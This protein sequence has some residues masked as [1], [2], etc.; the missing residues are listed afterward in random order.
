M[1]VGVGTGL[2]GA[3]RYSVSS[4]VF[5]RPLISSLEGGA[6]G[7]AAG[8]F[9]RATTAYYQSD[10]AGALV[11]ASSGA[12]RFGYLASLNKQALMIEPAASNLCVRSQE[13]DNAA[14]AKTGT[15]P[16]VVANAVNG[17]DGTLTA[18]SFTG[19]AATDYLSL[20]NAVV[21]VASNYVFS[22][23]LRANTGTPAFKV[24]CFDNADSTPSI[25]EIKTLSTSWARYPLTAS[26]LADGVGASP[27]LGGFAGGYTAGALCYLWGAQLELGTG[28]RSTSYIP[29]AAAVATRD[30]DY[31]SYAMPAGINASAGTCSCWVQLPWVTDSPPRTAVSLSESVSGGTRWLGL[32]ANNGAFPSVFYGNGSVNNTVVS[33]I[34]LTG[35]GTFD[36]LTVIWSSVSGVNL[37]V[38]GTLAGTNATPSSI[39]FTGQSILVGSRG[40]ITGQHLGGLIR[41][42]KIWNRVISSAE[43]ATDFA[44]GA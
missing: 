6:V 22:A 20:V 27:N 9:T 37:Y 25:Q 40:V 5:A 1:P 24:G 28:G 33:S 15:P 14:W 21:S 31:L 7:G 35:P 39:D 19:A 2:W 41:N 44:A 43:I 8:T 12:A 3:V 26:F 4:P 11:Q 29:T 13:F 17:P 38:N 23:Y 18:D 42:L 34:G 16:V 36:Q 10:T 32:R 30:A